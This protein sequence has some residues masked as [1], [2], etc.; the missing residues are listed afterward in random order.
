MALFSFTED[1]LLQASG[2]WFPDFVADES[3]DGC[4]GEVC[5]LRLELCL[6]ADLYVKY[7]EEYGERQA[8]P[9]SHL[10][11]SRNAPNARRFPY[12]ILKMNFSK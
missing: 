2:K 7:I 4:D 12:P 8:P 5:G 3:G 1:D 9:H 6:P 11:L 10:V